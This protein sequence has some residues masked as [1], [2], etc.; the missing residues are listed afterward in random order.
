VRKSSRDTLLLRNPFHGNV[1]GV[2]AVEDEVELAVGGAEIE[3]NEVDGDLRGDA[4]VE[5][6]QAVADEDGDVAGW[7][8]AD[9]ASADGL[10]VFGV[11][12]W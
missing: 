12:V 5:L 6:P 11:S 3:G 9:D 10:E 7:E 4:T 2:P 8:A 1:A